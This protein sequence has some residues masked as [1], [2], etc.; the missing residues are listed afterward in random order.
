ML[1]L[2]SFLSQAEDMSSEK[3]CF[4][5]K[6]HGLSAVQKFKAIQVSS[7][8]VTVDD[9]CLIIQM[10][11]HRREI[12]QRY[13]LSTFP[14][15]YVAFSSENA[16]RD[17]CQLKVEKEKVKEAD[18]L[19]IGNRNNIV[20][21]KTNQ[22]THSSETMQIQTL[23]D[24][25]LT[26]DQDQIKGSCRYLNADRYEITIEVRKNPKLPLVN[27]QP[28]EDQETMTLQTQLQ[29]TRGER[30]ELGSVVRNLRDK[31]HQVDITPNIEINRSNQKV[32][33]SVFLS[34]Q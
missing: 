3:Y 9:H 33:E 4:A 14:G 22:N 8:V 27:T 2:F 30:I 28:T 31:N 13:L 24:F 5:S 10:R 34:I 6:Q 17:P 26:I 20:I 29:L 1:L 32:S 16:R 25:E 23:K 15:A 11:P 7:D 19:D 12:I 21:N 18:S